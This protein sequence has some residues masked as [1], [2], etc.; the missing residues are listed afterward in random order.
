MKEYKLI[1]VDLDWTLLRND[2]TLS[3]KNA[4]ALEAAAAK[5]IEIVPCTGR[6]YEMIPESVRSLPF[7]HYAICINGADIYDVR[8]KSSLETHL[9]DKDLTIEIMEYI[10]TIDVIYDAYIDNHAYVSQKLYDKISEPGYVDDPHQIK[11]MT[12]FR[13]PVPE[14]KEY[15][16]ERGIDIQKFQMY[17]QNNMLLKSAT[18]Y[19]RS[20]YPQ[21]SVSSSMLFNTE[22]NDVNATK[23]NGLRSL[24]SHLGID[25]SE[26]MAFGDGGNDISMIEAAGTGI[27]MANGVE[28][29]RKIADFVTLSNEEDG[30]AYAIEKFI[31]Y[32]LN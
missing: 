23:G 3:K 9:I 24:A 19:I 15:I 10:D 21:V 29:V 20:K 17:T 16:K 25:I 1:T 2:K 12:A 18:E 32:S 27:A 13:T 26:T 6:Y 14:L 28:P 22:I 4:E 11:T 8:N 7:I 5:D 30:V 31:L